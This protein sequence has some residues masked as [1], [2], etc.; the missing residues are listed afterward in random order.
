M[1]AVTFLAFSILLQPVDF[2]FANESGSESEA[3]DVLEAAV[4]EPE[5]AAEEEV[6][7]ISVPEEFEAVTEVELDDTDSPEA[8]ISDEETADETE[9]INNQTD[10]TETV[11]DEIAPTEETL[12]PPE[13]T[14][15]DGVGEANTEEDRGTTSEQAVISDESAATTTGTADTH[16]S[17]T[18]SDSTLTESETITTP[19]ESSTS[20]PASSTPLTPA[21]G[22][23]K[24]ANGNEVATT[25]TSTSSSAVGNED[26]SSL[27]EEVSTTSPP[28]LMPPDESP[29]EASPPE[30]TVDSATQASTTHASTTPPV[31]VMY[32]SDTDNE[33]AFNADQCVTV[34][35]GSYYCSRDSAPAAGV[36][37]KIYAAPDADGDREIFV[38]HN[39]VTRQLTS[40]TVDDVA[41]EYD[42]S[43]NAIVWHRLVD[44]RYQIMYYDLSE[45]IETQ[46]TTGEDNNME[47]TIEGK[48][49]AW[50]HWDGADWELLLFDGVSTTAI[51][52]NEV[53]DLSPSINDGYVLW[54]TTDQTGKRAARV[55][56]ISSGATE[57][58]SGVDGGAVMN[59][60]F[61]LVYDTKYDNG[62]IVTTGFDIEG[63]VSMSLAA[64]PA[65]LPRDIPDSEPTEETRALIQ[66]KSSKEEAEELDVVPSSSD[67][68]TLSQAS[69]TTSL[70]EQPTSGAVLDLSQSTVEPLELTEY[71]LVVTGF[72]TTTSQQAGNSSSS[73]NFVE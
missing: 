65:E 12:L 33:Y 58:I 7:D 71:D 15:G 41:P 61:V 47:P 38:T 22:S 55:Y 10:P 53:P 45:D 1:F 70:N 25:S 39:G 3:E 56:D 32:V 37:D 35:D 24:E 59:P 5:T 30:S 51:T 14:V 34:A 72:A 29:D 69:S 48:Y 17:S 36:E 27:A 13:S 54:T 26:E 57:L 19:A 43:A 2:V 46:L 20:S 9:E 60:R 66:N 16:A 40:N 50:Q 18:E 21:G 67:P 23:G 44:G 8:T 31:V 49:V 73:E 52:D 42:I 6:V 63:G 68:L 4:D 28:S 11:R 62:D 64:L